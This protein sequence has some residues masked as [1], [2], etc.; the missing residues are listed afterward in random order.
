MEY[1][2]LIRGE[3]AETSRLIEMWSQTEEP[4]DRWAALLHAL[5]RHERRLQSLLQPGPPARLWPTRA[6]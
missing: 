2:Q 4:D 1:E 6:A 5:K 3:L